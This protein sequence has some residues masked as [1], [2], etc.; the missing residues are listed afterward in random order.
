MKKE[1][2]PNQEEIQPKV[3][4]RNNFAIAHLPH[5]CP[6]YWDIISKFAVVDSSKDGLLSPEKVQL[7]VE[8]MEVLQ[9]KRPFK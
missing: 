9:T 1:L 7:M 5:D 6:K 3:L 4:R 8:N 2:T